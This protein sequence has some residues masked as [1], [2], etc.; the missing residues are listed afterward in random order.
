MAPENLKKPKPDFLLMEIERQIEIAE[1]L[2]QIEEGIERIEK[3]IERL[4]QFADPVDLWPIQSLVEHFEV[5]IVHLRKD[6]LG[7]PE[8]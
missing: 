1:I 7:E 2:D 3:E 8:I 5:L 6:L 4:K